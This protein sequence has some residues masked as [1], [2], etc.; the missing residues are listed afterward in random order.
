MLIAGH[1]EFEIIV[2]KFMGKKNN[3][4]EK[5]IYRRFSDIEWLHDG[6]L[7]YNPGCRIPPLPEKN[8]WCNL[9]V[10]NNSMLEKRRKHIEEY[11]NYINSHKYLSQNPHYVTFLI[12]DFEKIRAESD[13]KT[14][15]LNR[16]SNMA[17]H[18]PMF[19]QVKMKGLS[20]IEDN[21]KL[22]KERENLVRLAKA[23]DF[24]FI[25]MKEYIKINEE[26]TEAI[27]SI[28][29][30]TKNLNYNSL[31]F[32]KSNDFED[33]NQNG[34]SSSKIDKTINKNYE[35][36]NNYYEKNKIFYNLVVSN[37]IDQLEVNILF[38]LNLLL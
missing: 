30:S 6:L 27:K 9:N 36:I 33:E 21:M 18:F 13:T 31:D 15:I 35:L 11:L 17:N 8:I 37:I 3:Y 5:T 16:I 14:S 25:N 7:K 32:N 10:N 26:K 38:L 2:R 23:T 24:L 34:N 19:K 29:F 12:E 1:Y 4:D 20:T 28:L 22:E